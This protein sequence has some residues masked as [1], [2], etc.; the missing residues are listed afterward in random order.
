[1]GVLLP[2]AI[3]LAGA[4]IVAFA[5]RVDSSRA[6]RLSLIFALATLIAA[7]YLAFA[8][9]GSGRDAIAWAAGGFQGIRILSLAVDGL[10]LPLVVLTA[11]LGVIAV[12]TSWEVR[13]RPAAH[14]ALLLALE[15]AVMT[16]FLADHLVLFYIAWEAVLIPMFFLI[17]VWGHEN[18]RAAAFKF[19]IYTFAGS[20]L[21][22][23][24][25]ITLLVSVPTGSLVGGL[26]AISGDRQ[27]L[28]FWLLAAGLLVKVPV[29]P[30]HTWLPDAHVEAPTA[31]SVMLAGVL[32]KMGG[33]G[34]IRIAL[35]AAPDAFGSAAPLLAALG[36]IGIV[37]G[38]VLALGQKDLKRLV[39]YSSVAHMG[40]MLLA[41]STGS[42]LGIGAAMLVMVSHGVV[43]GLLF[44]LVGALY[45]RT[46]TREIAR[47]GGLL[48]KIPVWGGLFVFGSLASL[49]LPG[50]S[51]FPGELL[52][53]L[54]G[55]GRFGWWIAPVGLGVAL[56]AVYNLYAVRAVAHGELAPGWD[57]LA[58]LGLRERC[59][60]GS[61]AVCIVVLGV[62]P[63]L[64]LSATETVTRVI[65]MTLGG[66]Q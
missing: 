57:A 54:E 10:S 41:V 40:F 24:G 29:V 42:A 25:I 48:A 56:A 23:I 17:A 65:A 32:L 1:M 34:L 33:Y 59:V 26:E 31:G 38:A 35:P 39:A 12:L 43:S 19:F 21:M 46:H 53:V 47:F 9:N 20:A 61:L 15:A 44:F 14:H 62:W 28:V 6:R 7:V 2:V 27:T 66:G 45:D 63:G 36:A 50:L 18:R 13:E 49:G 60:A 5:G 22:L 58:D 55:F 64:V 16:V 51:G 3:P 37:Y 30:L 52:A 4:L 11:F 8:W